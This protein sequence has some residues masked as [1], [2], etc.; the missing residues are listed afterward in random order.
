MRKNPERELH[1]AVAGYLSLA[2]TDESFF[3]TIGHG[4]YG[5]EARQIRGAMQRRVGQ[6]PGVPDVMVVNKGQAYFLELK[7][8]RGSLTD[9]QKDTMKKLS[10]AGSSVAV[11]R[12]VDEVAAYLNLWSVPTRIKKVL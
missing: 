8:L 6:K 3:T 10:A 2:L 5:G 4:V 11:C 9:A 12:S 1:Y 7:S